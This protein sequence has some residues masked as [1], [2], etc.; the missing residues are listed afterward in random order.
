MAIDGPIFCRPIDQA[1]P[2]SP[3]NCCTTNDQTSS[4][5]NDVFNPNNNP[6]NEGNCPSSNCL[7]DCSDT[8]KLYSSFSQD[9]PDEGNGKGPIFR[10]RLCVNVPAIANHL[11]NNALSQHNSETIGS[12]IS[13]SAQDAQLKSI[14]SAVTGCLTATCMNARGYEQCKAACSPVNI[15]VNSTMP[16]VEGVNGCLRALC[17]NQEDSFGSVPYAD[18]DIIGAGVSILVSLFFPLFSPCLLFFPFSPPS[19]SWFGMGRLLRMGG[20]RSFARISYN[21]CSSSYCL[22]VSPCTNSKHTR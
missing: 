10:Y 1:S 4:T 22:S 13:H 8:T 11:R 21:A 14:T 6:F 16:D 17:H 20:S 5:C 19:L 9:N 7:K 12:F 3:Q 18:E 15:L 2:L